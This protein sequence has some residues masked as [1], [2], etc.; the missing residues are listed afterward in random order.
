M[1]RKNL[2]K[3]ADVT[4]VADARSAVFD[5]EHLQKQALYDTALMNE[6]L[7]MFEDSAKARLGFLNSAV[8][9]EDKMFNL[10]ALKGASAGVGAVRLRAV[11]YRA[12]I[13]LRESGKLAEETL[14]DIAFAVEEA[15]EAVAD[16][17]GDHAAL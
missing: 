17:V 3:T 6:V 4:P 2:K 15:S 13:E 10:H 14:S 16:I 1:A 9:R 11:A 5:M 8:S 12:E 7:L